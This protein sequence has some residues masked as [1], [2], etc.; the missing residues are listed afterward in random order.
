MQ[1]FQVEYTQE[2]YNTQCLTVKNFKDGKKCGHRH[3]NIKNAIKCLCSFDRIQKGFELVYS[4]KYYARKK[5]I[6]DSL[7]RREVLQPNPVVL[8]EDKDLT[9]LDMPLSLQQNIKKTYLSYKKRYN[10]ALP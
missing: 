3:F 1:Y 6:Y 8:P 9:F 4:V 5:Y 7:I 2:Y 10:I